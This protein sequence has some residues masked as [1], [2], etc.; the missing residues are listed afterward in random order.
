VLKEAGTTGGQVDFEADVAIDSVGSLI[1]DLVEPDVS[2]LNSIEESI[3]DF[4]RS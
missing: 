4:T 1:T 2:L 3:K